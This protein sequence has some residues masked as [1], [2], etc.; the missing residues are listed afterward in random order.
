MSLHYLFGFASIFPNTA[1]RF[2]WIDAL[3][4]YVSRQ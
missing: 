2:V 3:G 1:D 4:S